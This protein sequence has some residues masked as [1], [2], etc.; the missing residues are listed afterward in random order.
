MTQQKKQEA[1]IGHL[2]TAVTSG[3]DVIQWV[4]T[5]K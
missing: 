2:A 1:T 5:R 3:R 4:R